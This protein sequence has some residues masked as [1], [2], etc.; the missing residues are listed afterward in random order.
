MRGT[1][2]P[3]FAGIGSNMDPESAEAKSISVEEQV[4][5]IDILCSC[6]EG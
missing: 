5:S 4:V 1:G 6:Q 2:C 3:C